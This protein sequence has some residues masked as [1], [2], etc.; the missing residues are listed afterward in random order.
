MATILPQYP[1][2]QDF[3]FGQHMSGLYLRHWLLPIVCFCSVTVL[4]ASAV[5]QSEN[6][7]NGQAD[8][9]GATFI[10]GDLS[11][12]RRFSLYPALSE[13]GHNCPALKPLLRGVTSAFVLLWGH[14]NWPD[15]GSD[16]RQRNW[17]HSHYR[18]IM[19]SWE[20]VWTVSFW[21]QPAEFEDVS[22][23]SQRLQHLKY[24]IWIQDY[25]ICYAHIG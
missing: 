8:G 10:W 7:K 20:P 15:I 21:S 6:R 3:A 5:G 22:L 18:A 9:Q 11:Y 25:V 16:L 4:F 14:S 19:P 2:R 13:Q 12:E 23:A 24:G 1:T 17:V